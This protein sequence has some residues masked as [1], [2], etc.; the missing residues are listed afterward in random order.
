MVTSRFPA[1]S[2]RVEEDHPRAAHG[3]SNWGTCPSC[4]QAF[5]RERVGVVPMASLE[6]TD[7]AAH[8]HGGDA[9][10]RRDA[11]GGPRGG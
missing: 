11:K 10:G 1:N 6:H 5:H 3:A 2:V 4:S 7:G 8:G 9:D